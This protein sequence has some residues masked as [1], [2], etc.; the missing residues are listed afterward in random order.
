MVFVIPYSACTV[1]LEKYVRR[2]STLIQF[3]RGLIVIIIIIFIIIIIVIII[4]FLTFMFWLFL[5][6]S[7]L[8]FGESQ[9]MAKG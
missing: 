1:S 4:C 3:K 9:Q 5:L 7:F 6:P 8:H 2:K